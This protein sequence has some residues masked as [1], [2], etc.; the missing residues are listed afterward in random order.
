L[1]AP[2]SL[3]DAPDIDGVL[4]KPIG[5]RFFKKSMRKALAVRGN[6][7]FMLLAS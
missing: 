4:K 6:V 5:R 7:S 2:G 3:A 1:Q